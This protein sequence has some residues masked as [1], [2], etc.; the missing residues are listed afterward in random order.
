MHRPPSE[1]RAAM[2]EPSQAADLLMRAAVFAG[3]APSLHN[4]QPWRWLIDRATLDLRL[5]PGRVLD[6]TDPDA[7]LAVLSCGTALHHARVELAASG[8]RTT[9]HRLPDPAD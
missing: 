9:V 5:E 6:T 2:S 1:G 7:R 4:S 8:W 3:Q